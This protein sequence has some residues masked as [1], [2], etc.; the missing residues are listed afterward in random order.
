MMSAFGNRVLVASEKKFAG[1]AWKTPSSGCEA[2]SSTFALS[3][4][5][6]DKFRR[7]RSR[8]P[9]ETYMSSL[10]EYLM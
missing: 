8:P 10:L 1:S 9:K 5:E 3:A 7:Y 6:F 4:I 2:K